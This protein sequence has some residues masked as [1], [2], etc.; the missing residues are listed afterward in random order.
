MFHTIQTCTEL[1][2]YLTD[3]Y[4]EGVIRYEIYISRGDSAG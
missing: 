4:T 3:Y 2:N 1:R